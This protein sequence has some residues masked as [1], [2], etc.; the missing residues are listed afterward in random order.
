[1][2]ILSPVA[3]PPLSGLVTKHERRIASQ[4]KTAGSEVRGC[5]AAY[6]YLPRSGGREAHEPAACPIP[7]R[8]E[9]SQRNGRGTAAGIKL[10]SRRSMVLES[11]LQCLQRGDRKNNR[12]ACRRDPLKEACK[13]L[14]I[15]IGGSACTAAT[16]EYKFSG[17]GMYKPQNDEAGER[18]G[19]KN[20]QY[21]VVGSEAHTSRSSRSR[22]VACRRPSI[23][24]TSEWCIVG[25]RDEV[26]QAV[27]NGRRAPL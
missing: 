14:D 1:M 9:V 19:P 16:I 7:C 5:V 25:R 12:C 15:D 3:W 26:E 4:A 21:N 23:C 20:S 6:Q 17:E 10:A 2:W 13:R 11:V 8:E 18:P 22:C 27:H 24:M